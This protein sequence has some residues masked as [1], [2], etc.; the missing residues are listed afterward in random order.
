MLAEGA[1]RRRP[2]GGVRRLVD[3]KV[4]LAVTVGAGRRSRVRHRAV[5]GLADLEDLRVVLGVVA[6]RAFRI[7]VQHQVL[8]RRWLVLGERPRYEEGGN[9][10]YCCAKYSHLATLSSLGPGPSGSLC[11]MP[12]WQSM[13]VRPSL[14]ILAWRALA[15]SVC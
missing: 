3:V 13:Q 8:A 6:A 10:R 1:I 12:K 7:A 2:L 15:L 11:A 5:L 14:F 4:A 9:D